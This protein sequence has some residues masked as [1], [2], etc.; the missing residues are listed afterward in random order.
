ME[1]PVL[2]SVYF[3]SDTNKQTKQQTLWLLVRKRTI[4]TERPP[5]V[6]EVSA[7]YS[8]MQYRYATEPTQFHVQPARVPVAC[9]DL[10]VDYGLSCNRNAWGDYGHKVLSIIFCFSHN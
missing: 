3:K 7:I 9:G 2:D 8:E 4:P 6:G 1:K 5:L 10:H